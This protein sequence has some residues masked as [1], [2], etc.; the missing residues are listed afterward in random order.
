MSGIV[1]S[2]YLNV[3]PGGFTALTSVAVLVLVLLGKKLF[4]SARAA[5]AE[6]N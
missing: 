5:A 6:Q 3:A 4:F 1:F 2:Y